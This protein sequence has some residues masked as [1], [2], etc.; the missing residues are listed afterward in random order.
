MVER[1]SFQ[2]SFFPLNPFSGD[3]AV[4]SCP[5]LVASSVLALEKTP[6]GILLD[7]KQNY[8]TLNQNG[9]IWRIGRR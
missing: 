7:S 2:R 5:I 9:S 3:I 1:S 4:S 8:D 6:T